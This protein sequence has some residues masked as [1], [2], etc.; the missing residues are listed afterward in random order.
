MCQ[1]LSHRM[2]TAALW[3][4]AVIPM[5]Q[6]RNRVRKGSPLLKVPQHMVGLGFWATLRLGLLTFPF[7]GSPVVPASCAVCPVGHFLWQARQQWP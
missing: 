4:G 5:V 3:A 6:S 1:V 2:L 7:L